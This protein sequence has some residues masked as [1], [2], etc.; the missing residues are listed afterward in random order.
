MSLRQR[1][2]INQTVD[3]LLQRFREQRDMA[4]QRGIPWQLEYW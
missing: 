4:K 2:Y 1:A 3:P